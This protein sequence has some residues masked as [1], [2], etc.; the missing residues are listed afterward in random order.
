ME[1][2]EVPTRDELRLIVAEVFAGSGW[3]AADAWSDVW[4]WGCYVRVCIEPLKR[5]PDGTEAI[6]RAYQLKKR[7]AQ[8]T[9]V[10]WVV[11]MYDPGM[12][13]K[14][15]QGVIARVAGRVAW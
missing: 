9:G 11:V 13:L 12:E 6:E 10:P 1:A 2:R 3:A 15:K 7:M 14:Q 5:R 4:P 8:T